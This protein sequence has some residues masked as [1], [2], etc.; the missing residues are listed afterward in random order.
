VRRLW[1]ALLVA[2]A[3]LVGGCS[4]AGSGVAPAEPSGLPLPPRPREVPV[5]GV[6][7][8]LLLTAE[9][10]AGLGLDGRP[11][12]DL[13][14]SELYPGGDVPACVMR[15]YEPL[16]VSVGLSIVTTTGIELFTSGELAAKVSPAEV[17]GFPAV[18]AVPT[19]SPDW[20]TV[21]VDLAPG[22]L[23][24]I[25]FADGGRRPAIPQAQLCQHAHTVADAVMTTLLSVR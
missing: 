21:V 18:V 9:Q 20:C 12:F 25:Q 16:A 2:T 11:E 14:P 3:V 19:R 5:D 15:G 7:P 6:D 22:Q 10:R 13:G 17:H 4:D 23:L 1:G 8:C 24:D